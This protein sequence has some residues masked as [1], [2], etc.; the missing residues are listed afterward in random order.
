MRAANAISEPGRTVFDEAVAA[1]D[2]GD[3]RKGDEPPGE[4]LSA[5]EEIFGRG[6]ITAEIQTEAQHGDEIAQHHS[7]VEIAA[8]SFSDHKDSP[9]AQ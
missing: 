1:D 3:A 5:E 8:N 4:P 9:F 7:V 2:G 6:R